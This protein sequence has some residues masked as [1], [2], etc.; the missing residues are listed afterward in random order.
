MRDE[1]AEGRAAEEEARV[2][3]GDHQL[4]DGEATLWK[5][6]LRLWLRC[7]EGGAEAVA[8]GERC[9]VGGQEEGRGRG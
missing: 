8:E 1:E 5:A 2:A 3:S 9:A 4:E 7:V 6:G